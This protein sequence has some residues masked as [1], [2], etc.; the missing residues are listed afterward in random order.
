MLVHAATIG[1]RV[2]FEE[3]VR[4]HGPALHRY[5]RRMLRDDGDVAEVVQDTFVAAARRL[6]TF[7]GDSTV[8]TWLFRICYRKIVDCRRIRRAVP[9]DDALL[10][11]RREMVQDPLQDPFTRVCGT[12]LVAAL[13]AALAE[14]P[15]RQRASWTLREIDELSFPEIGV[16]LGLTA[17]AVRGHH[18]RAQTGLSQRLRRWR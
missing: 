13:E 12:E 14:L 6:S 1:D 15:V 9:I 4:R 8:Q 7:R 2:A 17:D 11:P 3:L 10:V 5:A 18:R 16:V